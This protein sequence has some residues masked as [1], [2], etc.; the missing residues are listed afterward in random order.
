MRI[1]STEHY[2]HSWIADKL[3][4]DFKIEDVWQLPVTLQKV[5]TLQQFHNA[6]ASSSNSL[7]TSGFTGMLF[8]FRLFVGRLFKWDNKL[9]QTALVPGSIRARYAQMEA[10]KYDQLPDP[11]NGS[12]TPVYNLDQEFLAEIVNAT[13]HAA[14]HLG[15]V[16]LDE[17]TFTVQMTIYVKPKGTFG[18]GYMLLIKPFRWLIVYP[19]LMRIIRKKWKGYVISSK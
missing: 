4:P 19:T 18:K 3:L 17:N 16:P 13:V 6:F 1:G 7:E 11:G 15:L 10:L 9:P 8:R 12:F 2:K 5:H 14:I